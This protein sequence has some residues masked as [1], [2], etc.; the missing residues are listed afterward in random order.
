M[1]VWQAWFK[2]NI[3]LGRRWPAPSP[4]EALLTLLAGSAL[5]A[6]AEQ[7]DQLWWKYLI[8]EVFRQKNS[9]TREISQN[10][11]Q[12]LSPRRIQLIWATKDKRQSHKLLMNIFCWTKWNSQVFIFNHFFKQECNLFKYLNAA[13][14]DSTNDL[15][16]KLHKL[17]CK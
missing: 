1:H 15:T 6:K 9:T 12:Y 8:V 4:P 11:L 13:N 10:L 3:H 5:A 2:T 14:R 7:G 17:H 16:L